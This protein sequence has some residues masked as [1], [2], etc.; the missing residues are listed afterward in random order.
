MLGLIAAVDERLG[1]A[2]DRGIPWQGQL[3]TD[4]H[5]F[6]EQTAEGVIVMGYGTY[7]EFASPLHDRENFVVQRPGSGELRPGFVGVTDVE[8]FLHLYSNELVWV[9]GGAALFAAT[10]RWA[11]RLFLTR[12]E[13]DFHCTKFFPSFTDTFALESAAG[14]QVENGIPFHFEIWRRAVSAPS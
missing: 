5:Y 3:P 12:L 2:N 1:V 7:Q 14:P 11:D 8:S 10:M 6:R 9:I 13:G 4:A